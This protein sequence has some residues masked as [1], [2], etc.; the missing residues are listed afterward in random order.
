MCAMSSKLLMLT[1]K[2][3]RPLSLQILLCLLLLQGLGPQALLASSP[4]KWQQ[5]LR[6]ENKIPL[7]QPASLNIDFEKQR[8]YVVDSGNNRLVSFDK[9]GKQLNSFNAAGQLS[10]PVSTLPHGTGRRLVVEKGQSRLSIIDFKQKKV[11]Y[12][13]LTVEGN[14]IYPNHLTS[15]GSNFYI[16]DL[17]SGSICVFNNNLEYKQ[18][19]DKTAAASPQTF[20]ND[21][22]FKN[23]SLWVLQKIQDRNRVLQFGPDGELRNVIPLGDTIKFP[24]SLALDTSGLIYILDSHGG[25]VAVLDQTGNLK[26]RFLSQG[27][28][29]GQLYY[30]TQIR[31]DFLGRLCVVD[32]GNGRVEIFNR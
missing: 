14:V 17:M 8:Y 15:D 28:V 2:K 13:T 32:S 29:R 11:D 22:N 18:L 7:L 24:V 1:D 6:A 21:I 30:P 12:Q 19:I 3:S 26:Y 10:S 9:D 23:G 4:W 5:S 27:H 20:I 25:N 31:F 16:H